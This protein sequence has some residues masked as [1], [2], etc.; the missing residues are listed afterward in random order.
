MSQTAI[1]VE[2]Q[3]TGPAG[4][5]VT[6]RL[7]DNAVRPFPPT[8]ADRPNLVWDDRLDQPPSL[9]RGLFDNFTSLT[10]ALGVGAMTLKNGDRALDPYQSYGW[11]DVR[12]WRWTE[13]QT[14]AQAQSIYAGVCDMPGYNAAADSPARVTVGLYD[15]RPEL[16][17][18]LQATT[19][20]GGNGVGGVLYEGDATGLKG[21]VKPLAYG[22]LDNA[23]LPAPQVNAGVRAY[24]LHD[25]AFAATEQIF[26]RGDSAGLIDDGDLIGGAFD[27]ATPAAA[28][29]VTDPGR[30]LIKFNSAPVG[31]VTFGCRGDNNPTYQ[32]T[33]GP[34]LARMLAKAGVPGGR[35]GA[36]VAGLASTA[37]VGAWCADDTSASDVMAWVARSAPAALLPGRDGVWGATAF[38]PPGLIAADTIREDEVIS[39]QPDAA[40]PTPAG[41][42]R[43][44]WGRIWQTFEGSSLAPAL[45]GTVS[46]EQLAVEYRY[47]KVE[48]ATAKARFPRA[49]TRIQIETALRIEADA[50]ALANT[51][52]ATFGLRADGKPRRMWTV[53]LPLTAARLAIDLGATVRLTYSP[54]GIDDLFLLVAEETLRPRRDQTTWTLWG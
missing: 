47:A 37:I 21:T 36:S 50:T 51:L 46:E 40:A 17:K 42:V 18:P 38:G 43:V 39:L 25:G 20:A 27:A 3:L 4:E 33:T 26:D 52:M 7:S 53:V 2:I 34:V 41:E 8:D 23:H 49:W 11:G 45:K 9:R 29:Y 19:Y 32:E 24:Q 30:G 54:R 1:L 16:G 13:G 10:P 14:F 6:L 15:Y 5:A 48:S 44:G 31:T 22:R 35:I 12:V 28:H